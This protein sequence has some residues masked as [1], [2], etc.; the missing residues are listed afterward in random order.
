MNSL[1][2]VALVPA[3]REAV[4]FPRSLTVAK[5]A[6]EWVQSVVVK[7]MGL[8]LVPEKA[9]IGRK[10]GVLAFSSLTGK[11]API[12]FQVGVQIFTVSEASETCGWLWDNYTYLKMHFCFVGL[13]THFV[14]LY[15]GQ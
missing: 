6:H 2:V 7:S 3:P 8:S 5:L 11:L 12:W 1:H 15:M 14:S 9:G 10:P 13:W 4:A